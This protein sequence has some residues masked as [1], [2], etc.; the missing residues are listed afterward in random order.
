MKQDWDP[1]SNSV[2]HCLYCP[3]WLE[4]L[5]TAVDRI[6]SDSEPEH[7]ADLKQKELIFQFARNAEEC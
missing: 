5:I 3:N 2:R 1:E 4:M 7:D 6:I